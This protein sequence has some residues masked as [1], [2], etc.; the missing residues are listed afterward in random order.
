[1][2]AIDA[3]MAARK[4]LSGEAASSSQGHDG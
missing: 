4:V 2:I 1:M 3:E